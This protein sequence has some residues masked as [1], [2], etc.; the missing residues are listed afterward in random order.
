MNS[1]LNREVAEYER[2][3]REGTHTFHE[4]EV[5][6][7]SAELEAEAR[8]YTLGGAQALGSTSSALTGETPEERRRKIL[9]AT[10]GRLRKEEEELEHSCG[11]AGPAAES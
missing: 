8:A 11:T 9:D 6:E 5:Y 10:V 2:S 1:R 3:A 7:P 4:G